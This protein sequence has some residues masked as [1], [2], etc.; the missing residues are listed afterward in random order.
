MQNVTKA[1]FIT[2]LEDALDRHRRQTLFSQPW[3]NFDAISSA[4]PAR[5]LITEHQTGP[6]GEAATVRRLRLVDPPMLSYID[7]V[8]SN[9][10]ELAAYSA[11]LLGFD[12]IWSDELQDS[13]AGHG[14][15][16][17]LR[18]QWDFLFSV[19]AQ[20][21]TRYGELEAAHRV[22]KALFDSLRCMA[23]FHGV[24]VGS[25]PTLFIYKNDNFSNYVKPV[26]DMPSYKP[27]KWMEEHP[28]GHLGHGRKF[29]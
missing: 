27:S 1:Q 15:D 16:W 25:W 18:P 23:P 9:N 10:Y 8:E 29:F 22:R 12:P 2:I 14:L 17:F 19:A 11:V 24:S 6:R 4:N 5:E 7:C 28:E 13:F 21:N 26:F 20:G 3:N